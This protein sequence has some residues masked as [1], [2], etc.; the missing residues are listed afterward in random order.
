MHN[1]S[2]NVVVINFKEIGGIIEIIF[3]VQAILNLCNGK[4]NT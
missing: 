2:N 3:E 4:I 1:N